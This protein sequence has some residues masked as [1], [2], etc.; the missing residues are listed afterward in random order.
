MSLLRLR[1][2]SFVFALLFSCAAFSYAPKQAAST[3]A[4]EVISSYFGLFN[5]PSSGKPAFLPSVIV[6]LVPDQTYGWIIKLRTDRPKIKWCE[7]FTLPSKP[8][9]WGP[10]ESIDT[11]NTS[12]DGRTTT[13]ERTVA[14]DE[15]VIF[16]TWTVA[17]GDPKGRYVIRVYVEDSLVATFEFDVK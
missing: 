13:T 17:P 14:P 16:N 12:S 7:E 9:T 8:A 10:S 3:S 2:L 11:R 6:P 15:G 1:P 4:L 5:P